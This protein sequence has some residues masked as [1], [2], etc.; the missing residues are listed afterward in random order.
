MGVR[1]ESLKNL[2]PAVV[3]GSYFQEVLLRNLDGM[4][5]GDVESNQD[6]P[7]LAYGTF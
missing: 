3:H 1:L 5:L 7:S 2:L 6:K 4:F